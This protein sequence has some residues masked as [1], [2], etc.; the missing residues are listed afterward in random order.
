MTSTF[1]EILQWPKDSTHTHEGTIISVTHMPSANYKTIFQHATEWI[2]KLNYWI[3][4]CPLCALP[5]SKSQQ[6][7][8]WPG[9]VAGYIS[10]TI[11]IP[12]PIPTSISIPNPIPPCIYVPKPNNSLYV[13]LSGA[14][15]AGGLG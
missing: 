15:N 4:I 14:N 11:P 3:S 9:C 13:P 12:K 8:G 2:T 10:Y 5:N 1:A 7:Q 6:Q